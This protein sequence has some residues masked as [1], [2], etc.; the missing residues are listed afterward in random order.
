MTM[1]LLLSSQPQPQPPVLTRKQR[2]KAHMDGL[3]AQATTEAKEA[4]L[5][6]GQTAWVYL[7]AFPG[8]KARY[9]VVVS[10]FPAMDGS[11]SMKM[12]AGYQGNKCVMTQA[13]LSARDRS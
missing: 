3:L 6:P 5:K 13:S 9:E 4:K 12:V 1:E 7:V 2:R 10:R 8:E 11:T